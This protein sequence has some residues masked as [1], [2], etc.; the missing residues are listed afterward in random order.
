MFHSRFALSLGSILALAL[1]GCR[2]APKSDTADPSSAQVAS[3]SVD[4]ALR[5]SLARPARTEEER[6]RDVYRHPRET[7]EF[8]GLRD[9][10]NVVELWAPLGFYTGVL[11][12]VLH[13]HGKLSVTLFEPNNPP[14]RR[15]GMDAK[16]TERLDKSPEVYDRVAR[17]VMTP[18]T[19]SFG[20]DGS[21]DLVLTFRNVHNWLAEGYADA[22]FAA[23]FRV[24]KSGGALGV[25]DHRG[26][27]GMT[28]AQ[29]EDTGYVPEDTILALAAKAGFRLAARSEI[30]AN[31]KDTKDYPK[32]VWTLPPMYGM[33]DVDRAKYAA[34]G[35][36]DRMTLKFVKP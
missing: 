20:P 9:D 13:D 8:F 6:A 24:L 28:P 7:L 11:A 22:V 12:P 23:A 14:P 4:A 19:F 10:M 36:S 25:V 15:F 30:N 5:A 3:A 35:E 1:V 21:A 16:Y 34:I 29:I 31:P 26:A 17:I 18:G 32:G 2:D 33:K 27:P